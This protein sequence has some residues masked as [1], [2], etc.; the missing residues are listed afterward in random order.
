LGE[1]VICLAAGTV[2]A[3]MAAQAFTLTWVH[4]VEHTAIEEDYRATGGKLLLTTARI[5]GS[6]A[7]FDPPPGSRLENGWWRYE[8]HMSLDGLTLARADAPGDWRI[9]LE[10]LCRS[11]DSYLAG[12]ARDA[13]V[14]ISA[15]PT[16]R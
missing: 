8:P 15:C 5:K 11:V 6:G 16:R 9:C 14:R 4:S 13:P 10:N 3:T 12:A 7:G 2:A 1:S